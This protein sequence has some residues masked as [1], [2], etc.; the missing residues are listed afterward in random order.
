MNPSFLI[1]NESPSTSSAQHL[2]DLSTEAFGVWPHGCSP[3]SKVQ[4]S[5]QVPAGAV[6]QGAPSHGSHTDN[7]V[8]ETLGFSDFKPDTSWIRWDFT[9]TVVSGGFMVHTLLI[10]WVFF[11]LHRKAKVF[12]L[13]G[14]IV[15]S[16]VTPKIPSGDAVITVKLC[17][18]LF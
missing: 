9:A 7:T 16:G 2:W 17:W 8:Q 13:P 14:E 12:F 1:H 11:N 3:T 10:R 4:T 15:D 5:P 6:L 18:W